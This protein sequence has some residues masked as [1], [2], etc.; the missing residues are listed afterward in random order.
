M[1]FANGASV[2]TITREAIFDALKRKEIY[3]TTAICP[4]EAP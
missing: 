3:A 4:A 2:F 1:K